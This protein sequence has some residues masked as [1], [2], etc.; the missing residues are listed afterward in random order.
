ME[1]GGSFLTGAIYLQRGSIHTHFLPNLT[2][3]ASCFAA[4]ATSAALLAASRFIA[5]F[6]RL[7]VVFVV[8][9]CL[10]LCSHDDDPELELELEPEPLCFLTG[11]A[12]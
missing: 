11:L 10:S 9:T 1:V 12:S 3:W 4:E 7:P 6:A 5:L 2:K 8:F